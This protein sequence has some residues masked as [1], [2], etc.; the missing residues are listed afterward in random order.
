VC[1]VFLNDRGANGVMITLHIGFDLTTLRVTFILKT[2]GQCVIK[3]LMS[4]EL[5]S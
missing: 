2:Y 1:T 4:C 3:V 5:I